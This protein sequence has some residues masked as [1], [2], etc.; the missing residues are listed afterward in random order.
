MNR[1]FSEGLQK[2]AAECV[3]ACPTGA[4]VFGEARKPTFQLD[5]RAGK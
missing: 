4:I 3:E 5:L 2:V 1:E